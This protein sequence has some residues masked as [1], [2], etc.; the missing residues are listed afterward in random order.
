MRPIERYKIGDVIPLKDGTQVTVQEEYNPHR[1]AIPILLN[2]F[3]SYCSYCEVCVSNG[4]CLDVEHILPKADN[5]NLKYKWTNFLLGCRICN[6]PGGK[7]YRPIPTPTMH[8]PDKN[9]TFLSLEYY[10]S[11]VVKVNPKLNVFAK[12]NAQALIDYLHLNKSPKSSLEDRDGRNQMRREVWKVANDMLEDYDAN[13]PKCLK[14]LIETVKA[15]GG[16][17]I[18]FTVF[19]GHDEVRKA[20]IEKFPGTAAQC[21]DANNHY[22]PIDRHPENAA[23]P[24]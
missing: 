6:G 8:Q 10:E 18:W 15:R 4:L 23:D 2:N 13:N 24:T 19:K 1:D 5:P 22:E 3:G 11:G 12:V 7:W 21:F 14:Y 20:L 9:N 17:S 16:W